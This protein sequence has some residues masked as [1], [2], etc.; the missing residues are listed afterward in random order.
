MLI[1][2]PVKIEEKPKDN[3][4]LWVA[5]AIPVGIVTGLLGIGGGMLMVPVMVLALKFK[6]HNAVATSL[7][8]VA[9][10]SV[11]G[12]IGYIINGLGVPNLPPYSIGY[13]NLLSWFLLAVTG[14]GMAQVGAI[15][16]HR[17]PAKQ[18]RYVFIGVM[19]Y[20]GLKM[21]GVFA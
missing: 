16:A 6:M 2:T 7:A 18:L 1:R 11:G 17:L 19:F 20:M 10:T 15:T 14:V 8:F 3:P 4:W 12:I 5:W 9:I 21:L 13:V